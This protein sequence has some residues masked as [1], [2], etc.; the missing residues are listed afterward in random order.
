MAIDPPNFDAH[1]NTSINMLGPLG[2]AYNLLV[3]YDDQDPSKIVPDLAEKWD[4]SPDGS[5]ITFTLRRGVLWHDGKPFTAAD[6]KATLD[7]IVSPPKGVFSPRAGSFG[8]IKEVKVVDD[9]TVQVALKYP[10][11]SLLYNIGVGFNWIMPKHI[12]DERGDMKKSV[13]GTG[14]FKFTRFM[15]G[16]STDLEKNPQYFAPGLPYLD[17]ITTYVVPDPGAR[18]AALRTGQLDY[19]HAYPAITPV[20]AEIIERDKLPIVVQTTPGLGFRIILP[21]F[22][23]K[24]WDDARV[25]KAVSIAIDRRGSIQ[26]VEKG[27][28]V[29]GGPL[30]PPPGGQW[31]LPADE[32]NKLPGYRYP[33]DQDI[34]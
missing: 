12:L 22:K 4:V 34:A 16:V 14:A 11:A 3:Q 10:T 5:A 21:N 18:F 25:R 19:I 20:E 31:S 24:P 26:I 9:Y 29:A 32:I 6:V 7:R 17:G 27:W 8:A 13:V 33:K 1:Q 15:S 2:P 23:V 28:G 30:P